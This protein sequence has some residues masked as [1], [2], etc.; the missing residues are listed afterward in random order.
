MSATGETASGLARKAGLATTTLTR[1]LADDGSPM[2]GLRSITKIAL[3][4]GLPPPFAVP[5]DLAQ[6]TRDDALP[7]AAGP[8][9][10]AA[11]VLAALQASGN[12]TMALQVK[13]RVLEQRGVLPGDV[14]IVDHTARASA[15][16]LVCAQAFRWSEAATDLLLR[17]YEPPY[18]LAAA[19]DPEL[20]QQA[21]RPLL[22]DNER[23]VIKGVVVACLR[24]LIDA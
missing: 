14:V 11:A 9:S 17:V 10:R 19:A 5:V 24:L 12:G 20:A 6:G 2:L 23:V 3:A 22:V 21:R 8:G 7:F 18:L 15:G 16:N 4:A 13:S 1:F